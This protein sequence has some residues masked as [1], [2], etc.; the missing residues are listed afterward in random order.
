[1][2]L[3][4]RRGKYVDLEEPNPQQPRSHSQLPALHWGSETEIDW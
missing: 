2:V 4:W 1:M 3:T